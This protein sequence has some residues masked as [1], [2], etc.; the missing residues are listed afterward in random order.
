MYRM[1]S[2]DEDLSRS[3]LGPGTNVAG[4]DVEPL[5]PEIEGGGGGALTLEYS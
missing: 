5:K 2:G 3:L 4:L 1:M